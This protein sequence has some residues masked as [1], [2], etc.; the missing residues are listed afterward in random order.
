MNVLETRRAIAEFSMALSVVRSNWQGFFNE[1]II[2]LSGQARQDGNGPHG[3]LKAT[4]K[5]C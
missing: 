5:L 4:R 3:F 2:C 1:G